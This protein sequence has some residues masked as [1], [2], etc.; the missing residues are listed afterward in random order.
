LLA[1]GQDESAAKP[2][3]AF[4]EVPAR[5]VK[6]INYAGLLDV[7]PDSAKLCLYFTRHPVRSFR[8][9]EGNWHEN[10]PPIRD[11]EDALRVIDV[12]SWTSSYATRLPALPFH[13]SFF[14]DSTALCIEIP[15]VRGGCTDHAV[16]YLRTGK[17]DERLEPLKLGGLNF[18]YTALSDSEILGSGYR[19]ETN[20]TDV[21]AR[22]A[23]PSY[24]EIQRV[25]FAETRSPSTGKT[26][27]DLMVSSDR[28]TFVYSVDNNVVCRRASDLGVKWTRQMKGT[29]ETNPTAGPWRVAVSADGGLVAAS[30]RGRPWAGQEPRVDV[31]DGKDGTPLA[32]IPVDAD[33]A[34]ALSPDGRLLA[35]G[36]RVAMRGGKQAG[37]RKSGTQ[38]TVLL[39][40]IASGKQVATLI[41]DRFRGG[42][43]EFLYAGFTSNGIL[44]TPDNKYLVTSGLNTRIWE[45]RETR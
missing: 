25:S 5:L 32:A 40:D 42:G 19:V 33:E 1:R 44:F 7:S 9:T 39:F 20:K 35:A 29:G 37:G 10:T 27:S 36:K 43:G 23:V 17:M 30:I 28:K 24:D 13:G 15:G 14:A 41:Q 21:L 2:G 18:S 38:P 6:E 26:E 34:I 8:E 22:V 31:Y 11:S 45:I 4:G 16:I 3:T 12:D